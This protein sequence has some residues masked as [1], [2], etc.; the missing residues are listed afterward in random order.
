[1]NY[2]T[3]AEAESAVKSALSDGIRQIDTAN[4]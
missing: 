2:F 3:P 1:M 4:A